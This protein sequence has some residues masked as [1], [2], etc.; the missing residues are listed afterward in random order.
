M[1]E[2]RTARR[3][4]PPLSLV[5]ATLDGW[6]G[7]SRIFR[8]HRGAVDAVGGEM[9][10]VDGSDRPPPTAEQIGPRTT[11]IRA[12]GEG[13]FQLR[14]RAYAVARGAIIAQTEDHC[15]TGPGWGKTI[16]E[17]HQ[18]HPEAAVIGGVVENGSPRRMEDWAVFFIGHFRDMP[19]VG[20][21][22]RVPM[23]GLT[24]VSYKKSALDGL[25]PLGKSGI[26]EAMHQRGLAARGE[27]VLIDDRLRV[28]HEQSQ[29]I[30]RMVAISWHSARTQAGM[31]RE[32][33]TPG[34]FIRLL[35]APVSS[36]VYAALITNAVMRRR[37]AMRA[38]LASLPL[39]YGLLGLR[40]IGEIVGY[41]AGPGD[42][43]RRFP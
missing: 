13:V 12:P 24:N 10:V 15:A 30:T 17:L 40:A 19:G 4:E 9:I 20:E 38:Y 25:E 2:R 41:A 1:P 18:E 14:A 6:P 39:V 8:T 34:A 21:G 27:V 26:N 37:Y 22:H 36:I 7:Y 11:W 35:A 3:G 42:S 31:R 5:V 29:G 32:R 33:M 16:V 28:S 23:A 43:A